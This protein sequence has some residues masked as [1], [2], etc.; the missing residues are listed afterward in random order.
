MPGLSKIAFVLFSVLGIFTS[1]AIIKE[2]LG[3]QSSLGETLCA[4]KNVKTDCTKVITSKGA[5]VFGVINISDISI[6]YFSAIT[7]A[8]LFLMVNTDLSHVY[9]LSVLGVP[10]VL[11]SVYYQYFKVKA[12][13]PLCL[14]IAGILMLQAIIGVVKISEVLDSNINMMSMTIMIAAFLMTTLMWNTLVTQIVKFIALKQDKIDYFKFKRN[15]DLFKTVLE[16]SPSISTAVTNTNEIV[17]GNRDAKLSI[18]VVTSPFC[19]H[20]KPVHH[21]ITEILKLY[22]SEV[23]ITIRFSVNTKNT[24]TDLYKITTRLIEIYHT[25]GQEKCLHAIHDI[26]GE[27]GSA[28]WFSIWGTA[29]RSD[30][31]AETIEAQNTWCTNNGINFTPEI[32]VNGRSFPKE[33]Q[34]QDLKLFIEDL[35]ED[36]QETLLVPV[37]I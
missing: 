15:Y 7:I 23:S 2:N 4:T 17:F 14:I 20:C 29:E 33:Y 16:K 25:Q 32:L 35:A 24:E 11:F 10:V 37:L 36:C 8:S 3:I 21:T 26:Y 19:G 12:W 31:Y 30:I 9:A 18:V 1:I 22:K 6:V 27:M 5:K 13:C 34:R 28:A